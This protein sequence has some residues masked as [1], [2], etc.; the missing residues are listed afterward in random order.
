MMKTLAFVVLAACTSSKGGEPQMGTASATYGTTTKTLATGAA[1]K[2]VD[3]A[4]N[5][6]V[7][8]G[9]GGVD[10]STN[11]NA[12]F[13]P[14]GMYVTMSVDMTNPGMYA[15]APIQVMRS[16]GNHID[17]E[18]SDGMVTIDAIDT[19]V[20]GSVTFSVTGSDGTVS[21]MGTFDVKKCF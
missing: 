13:P 17:A 18:I 9:D 1:I 11:L 8:L 2:D 14:E 20:S 12:S 5:M 10:C 3:A 6:L 7:Q 21:A 16:T 4:G 19:R 15:T